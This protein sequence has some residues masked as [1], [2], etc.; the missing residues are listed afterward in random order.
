MS[1]GVIT[2]SSF[3]KALWPGVKAWYGKAYDEYPVEWKNLFDQ[4]TSSRQ[5][6]EFVGTSGYGLAVVKNEGSPITYDTERQGFT[7]RATHITYALGFVVTREAYDDDMYD[8]VAP[9]KAQDLAFSMRQTKEVVAANIYNRAFNASFTYGD[10]VSLINAAHPQVAGGTLS[11]TLSTASD[12]SEASLEQAVIDIENFVND[13]GLRIQVMPK[14]LII[15]TT[16][17]FE[18]TRILKAD[19]RVATNH[20]DPN[21]LKMFGSIP[22]IVKNHYLTDPDAWFIRTNIP[23]GKGMLYLER[24]ADAFEVDNDFDTENAKFKATARYSFVAV[25][26]PRCIY[27]SPG[28]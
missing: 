11:N 27:G 26:T 5:Y 2:S 1:G 13:R 4:D 18:A 16:L 24:R 21:V 28:A 17:E 25:D 6:E 9:R 15:P 12:L 22:E 10:G 19:G 14:S 8:V 7:T 3:A 23:K 20:N